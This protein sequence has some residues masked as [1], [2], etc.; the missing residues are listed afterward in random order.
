MTQVQKE[1]ASS[2]I[3]SVLEGKGRRLKK[4]KGY[5]ESTSVE[6]KENGQKLLRRKTEEWEVTKQNVLE[7]NDKKKAARTYQRLL[8]SCHV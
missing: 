5:T 4:V 6:G 1:G 8:N 7:L 3:T 2:Q